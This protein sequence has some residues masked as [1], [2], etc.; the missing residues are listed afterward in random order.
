MRHLTMLAAGGAMVLAGP[1][2]ADFGDELF[3]LIDDGPPDGGVFGLSVDL[4]GAIA[5]VREADE[6][7][8][9]CPHPRP[10]PHPH[11]HPCQSSARSSV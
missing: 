2:H 8:A 7:S 3:R 6:D 4:S 10:R 11:P 9:A 5:I 1:V